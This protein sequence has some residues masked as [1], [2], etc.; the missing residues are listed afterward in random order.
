MHTA[1]HALM[2]NFHQPS[3]NLDELLNQ[4]SWEPREILMA[5]DRMPRA[6]WDYEDIARVHLSLSGSLLETLASPGFQQRVYGTVK[7][8]ELL[9]FYQNTKIFEVTGTGYYHP[10]FPLIPQADWEAQ[11]GR[12][13]DIGR[14]VFWRWGFPGFWPPEMGFCME[15]IPILR[16][17]GY[18][19]VMVDELHVEA[20]T[21][22]SWSEL[23]YRPHLA[24]YGGS[25]IVVV[26]RDRDLSNAQES[27]EEPDWFINEVNERT[28]FCDFP[29]LVLTATD[30]DN[31]GWFR[32]TSEN[33]FW[34]AFYRPLLEKV[35]RG[36]SKV[37]PIF[38][39][40]YL[41]RFGAHG[42]VHV[43]PGAWNTGG[44]SGQDFVQWTG[45]P[46]QQEALGRLAETS[47]AYHSARFNADRINPHDRQ[48]LIR[49]LDEAYWR[50][51]RAETSC[52]FFWGEAWVAKCHRDLDDAC[53]Y[54]DKACAA[55]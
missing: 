24:R 48:E 11:L 5:M 9:W 37:R 42:E 1:Y 4:G 8:G 35:R 44:H 2:L 20:K 17:M 50:L 26:V 14:H 16:Q 29:P 3:G 25:E 45:S 53:A 36:Q 41:D 13:L 28:K 49:D 52:H 34:Y 22:M 55:Y 43:H 30:G 12:W 21:K 15:M 23:R 39:N 46:M 47:Q 6:L 31:G 51:L 33:N 54:L 40:E 7:V 10:V 38:I 27:G 32:N 19:Y 18:R